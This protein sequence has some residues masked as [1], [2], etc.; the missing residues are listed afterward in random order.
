M[1]EISYN[2]ITV[3]TLIFWVGWD[4]LWEN[5]GSGLKFFLG[6]NLISKFPLGGYIRWTGGSP[7]SFR[8]WKTT[9]PLPNLFFFYR[10]V[11][12]YRSLPHLP[13]LFLPLSYATRDDGWSVSLFCSGELRWFGS[14]FSYCYFCF[15]IN[16]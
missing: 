1:G 13:L 2:F 16:P 14:F 15:S 4:Y 10:Y 7:I 9:T 11:H 5:R 3:V 8:H 6:S 12:Q